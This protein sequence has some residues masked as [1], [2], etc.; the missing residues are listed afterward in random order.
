MRRRDFL[1]LWGVAPLAPALLDRAALAASADAGWRKYEITYTV[2]VQGEGP[3]KL[4]LPVPENGL[5]GHQRL[6]S[7]DWQ[8]NATRAGFH[9]DARG[10]T[11]LFHAFWDK[12]A[13]APQA[14]V[15][16]RVATR[17]FHADFGAVRRGGKP[18]ADV[19]VYLK[20]NA[21]LPT[22]GLVASTAQ[23]ITGNLQ[24]PLEKAHAIYQWMVDNTFRDPKVRGCGTGDI[25]TMLETGYLGGKCA[26]LSSLFVGLARA[27]GIPAR[28]VYGMRVG[29]SDQFK[30]LGKSGDVSKA[31][32]CRAEFWLEGAGWIPVDPADVRK[33]V[34]D[35]KLPLADAQVQALSKRL[36][37]YWEMNWVGFNSARDTR[38]IPP[39]R[40]PLTY[41]M[42]PYAE[43]AGG[44]P[45]SLDPS[46]FRYRIESRSI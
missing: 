46:A 29:E 40:A 12:T 7:A 9:R 4:W 3:I 33:V 1:A 45:N 35:E 26:D 2:E 43:T 27:S 24:D 10:G 44:G 6:L 42:Y 28:D 34:L 25:R 19:A 41:F 17:D 18:P 39:A 36:F 22:S 23:K 5:S 13:P 21:S 38:L 20:P 15:T 31:Q 16:L 32:H 37:G 11:P 30:C 14:T 8:G